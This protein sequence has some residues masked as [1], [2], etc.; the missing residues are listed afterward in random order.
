[1]RRIHHRCFVCVVCVCRVKG[2]SHVYHS[3]KCTSAENCLIS[4]MFVLTH[5]LG[6]PNP[7][8]GAGEDFISYYGQ[9]LVTSVKNGIEQSN[10]S[11]EHGYWLPSCTDHTGNLGVGS[12]YSMAANTTLPNSTQNV[13]YAQVLSDW[14]YDINRLDHRVLQQCVLGNASCW[15]EC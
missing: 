12:T 13:T 8:Y 4:D 11:Y 15:A 10:I 1:M 7:P 3:G 2:T 14:F 5:R 6:C 9:R